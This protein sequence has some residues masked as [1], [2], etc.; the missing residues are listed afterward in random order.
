MI[1]TQVLV[2]D[3]N[4]DIRNFVRAALEPEGYDIVEVADGNSALA[5]MNERE[6]DGLIELVGG[7]LHLSYGC[8]SGRRV[9]C[10]PQTQSG[11]YYD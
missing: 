7:D 5:K 10:N 8:D 4:A 11:T 3:D 9:K 2:V 6:P 1:M